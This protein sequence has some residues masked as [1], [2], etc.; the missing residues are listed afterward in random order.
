MRVLY[1]MMNSREEQQEKDQER[2]RNISGEEYKMFFSFWWYFLFFAEHVEHVGGLTGMYLEFCPC[3]GSEGV[4][5]GCSVLPGS[6]L[7]TGITV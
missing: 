1:V 6:L 7:L 3:R 4:S 2:K 5:D